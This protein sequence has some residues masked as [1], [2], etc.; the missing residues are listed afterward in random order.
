MAGKVVVAREVAGKVVVARE[1]MGEAGR[2]A[3][4]WGAVAREGGR[5]V[6]QEAAVPG[7]R[8]VEQRWLARSQKTGHHSQK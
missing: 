5:E 1:V 4:A 6:A 2:A 3:A 8:V 7:S